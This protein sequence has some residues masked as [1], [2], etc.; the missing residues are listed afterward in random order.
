MTIQPTDF[1][2]FVIREPDHHASA[3]AR[4]LGGRRIRRG[5]VRYFMAPDKARQFAALHAAGFWPVRRAGAVM[6][7]RDPRPKALY[8]ALRVCKESLDSGS[9]GGMV[10][11]TKICRGSAANTNH[12]E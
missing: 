4:A 2:D 7:T 9:G 10:P 12:H 3:L 6:F 11:N 8:D 5:G 1:G